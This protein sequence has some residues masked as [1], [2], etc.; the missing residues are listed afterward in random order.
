MSKSGSLGDSFYWECDQPLLA[1]RS[2]KL[3]LATVALLQLN[4]VELRGSIQS[5][6]TCSMLFQLSSTQNLDTSTRPCGS[7]RASQLK[8]ASIYKYQRFDVDYSILWYMIIHYGILYYIMVYHLRN[9]RPAAAW[10]QNLRNGVACETTKWA[11]LSCR[12]PDLPLL[13]VQ[14]L[15]VSQN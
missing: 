6:S 2:F 1:P 13:R 4:G 8:F 11:R 12:F 14:D 15:G 5:E 10:N 7:G 9:M 3:E